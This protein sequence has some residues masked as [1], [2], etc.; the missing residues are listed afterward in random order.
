VVGVAVVVKAVPDE[1]V[2]ELLV[3][4]FSWPTKERRALPAATGILA[5]RGVVV[6][7]GPALPTL[8]ARDVVGAETTA[9][10][11]C[12][13]DFLAAVR[14]ELLVVRLLVVKAPRRRRRGRRQRGAPSPPQSRQRKM[15]GT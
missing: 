15:R 4:G 3:L 10:R 9:L 11:S 2:R 8:D 13:A 7:A 6:V 14:D 5:A 1:E 12:T